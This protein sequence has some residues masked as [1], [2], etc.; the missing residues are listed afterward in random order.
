MLS[1]ILN[2]ANAAPSDAPQIEQCKLLYSVLP[3]SLVSNAILALLL[4]VVQDEVIAPVIVY[5]WLATMGVVLLA[6]GALLLAWLRGAHTTNYAPRWLLRFRISAIATGLTWGAGAAL[7]FPHGDEV[8]Q[9]YLSFILAGL[10]A[11][12]STSLAIDRLSVLGFLVPT[13]IPQM[14]NFAMEGTATSF[15]MCAMVM[16]Y[17]LFIIANAVRVLTTT[18]G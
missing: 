7:L 10:T 5:G 4:A 3:L 11:G 14:V 9:V 18:S 8:H 1:R 6:R 2:Y 15:S 12:A 16:L 17:L 13:Q